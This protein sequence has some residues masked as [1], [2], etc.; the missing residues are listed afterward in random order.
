MKHTG[1]PIDYLQ[2]GPIFIIKNY[3]ISTKLKRPYNNKRSHTNKRSKPVINTMKPILKNIG[4]TSRR[5][6]VGSYLDDWPYKYV[7][8]TMEK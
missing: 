3:V 8:M 4:D 6:Q 7:K 5:I 1:T 2:E